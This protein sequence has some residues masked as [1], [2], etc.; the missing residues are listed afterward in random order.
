VATKGLAPLQEEFTKLQRAYAR[1]QK[2]LAELENEHSQL[3]KQS[4][5]LLDQYKDTRLE[6]LQLR[7]F[8]EKVQLVDVLNDG[9]VYPVFEAFCKSRHCAESVLFCKRAIDFSKKYF[10][11]PSNDDKTVMEMRK[12]AN[13][14][15]DDFIYGMLYSSC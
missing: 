10:A 11:I 15:L 12:E 3:S 6:V 8:Y 1:L 14:I 13:E 4:Q 9:E 7:P 5:Y 2:H